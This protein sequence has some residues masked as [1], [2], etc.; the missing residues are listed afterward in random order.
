MMLRR[1][2]GQVLIGALLALFSLL[3]LWL[4]TG[5]M[6]GWLSVAGRVSGAIG[7]MALL[8]GAILSARL[9]GMDRPFGGLPRLFFL[10]HMLGFTAFM[11]L[12]G[13]PLFFA[14]AAR[15]PQTAVHTILLPPWSAWSLWLGWLALATMMVFLAPSFHFFGRP[16]FDRWKGIHQLSALAI[17]LGVAHAVALSTA[18]PWLHGTYIAFGTAAIAAIVW[19]KGLSRKFSRRACTVA[20]VDALAERVVEIELD[21]QG[22]I[23]HRPGQFVYLGIDDPVMGRARGQEHP[24][25]LTSAPSSEKLKVTVKACGDATRAMQLLQPGA[26]AWVEGPYGD[27]FERC[28]PELAELWIAGGIGIAPF[29]ARIRECALAGTASDAT[30]IYC[31]NDPGRAYYLQELRGHAADIPGLEIVPHYFAEQGP[32]AGEFL[33]EAVA[34]LSRREVYVCGPPGLVDIVRRLLTDAGIARDFV[35]TEA[36]DF[37]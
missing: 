11:A 18:S 29:V 10:H 23:R 4:M 5:K 30:L 20:S 1:R 7:L 28:A 8:L 37:L 3:A 22:P 26:R 33:R 21:I 13:H 2:L 19:R 14:F 16:G 9:V 32:L 35:H 17:M 25:T 36:F 27:F 12:L 24:F 34:D 15:S 6:D 31:A